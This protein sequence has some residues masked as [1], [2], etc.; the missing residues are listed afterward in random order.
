MFL[1]MF[2]AV[3]KALLFLCVGTIEQRIASRDIEDMRGLYAVM[4]V[5]AHHCGAGRPDH[6]SAALRHAPGQ[7]DGH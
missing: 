6:D 2:H 7:V 4:P 1:I 5:T 3:T